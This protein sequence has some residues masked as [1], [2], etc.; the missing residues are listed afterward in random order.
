MHLQK[1]KK[2]KK[3]KTT[4][5]IQRTQTPPRLWPLTLWCDLDLKKADVIR[6][7][8]L[9]CT[10]VL[11]VKVTTQ[12][13]RSQTRTCLWSL[14]LSCDIPN[15]NLIV[16]KRAEIQSR[17]VNR[18]LWRKNGYVLRHCDLDLWPKVTNFNRAWAI[19]VSNHFFFTFFVFATFDCQIR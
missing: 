16:H 11:K 5:S 1:K 14:T 8:L 3:K 9:Y 17:E 6:C 10:L 19:A 4:R 12:G 13:Q 18:E 15:F 2:K 7:R